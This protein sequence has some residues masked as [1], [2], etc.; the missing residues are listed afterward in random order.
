MRH[1]WIFDVLED[2]RSYA[3]LNG[4]DDTAAK[5]EAALMAARVELREADPLP[6]AERP[7]AGADR[8]D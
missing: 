7:H 5:A 4:L 1:E 6:M 2:L 3:V 8:L